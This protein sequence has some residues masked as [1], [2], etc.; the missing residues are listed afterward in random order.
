MVRFS[1]QTLVK[2]GGSQL[3]PIQVSLAAKD[4]RQRDNA[5]LVLFDP[6]SRDIASA[7]RNQGNAMGQEPVLPNQ[8]MAS[9]V[10]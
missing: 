1:W 3:D 10:S 7:V 4:D 8:V 5:D 2:L 9:G 6:L